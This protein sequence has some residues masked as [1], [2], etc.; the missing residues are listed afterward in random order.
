M[1]FSNPT[2]TVPVAVAMLGDDD[3]SEVVW[4]GRWRPVRMLVLPV[5]V[6]S[7]HVLAVDEGDNVGILFNGPRLARSDSIGM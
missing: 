4:P 6:G 1:R 5:R 3:L 2:V 7:V